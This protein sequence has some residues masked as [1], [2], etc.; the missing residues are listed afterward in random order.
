MK[1]K[2]SNTMCKPTIYIFLL[3]YVI[4]GG[5]C[6]A[7]KLLQ[8]TENRSLP[9]AYGQKEDSATIATVPWK[10]F[11]TDPLLQA[12]IDTAL[13]RNQEL[14]STWQEIQIARNEIRMRRAPL[15]PSVGARLGMGI[16]K[17]GRYTSQG[18]GDASTEMEPGKEVPDPLADITAG[19]YANWELDIWKK[20]RNAKKASINRYL[21][22]IEGKNFVLTSL[23]AEVATAYFEL[24]ALDNEL[25]IVQQNIQLQQNAW[26]VVKVQKEAARTTELAVQKFGAELLGSQSLEFDIRQRISETEN[27]LNFLL[28]RFAQPIPR[29]KNGFLERNPPAVQAGVPSQLLANR[30]DIKQAELELAAA[31]LDVKTARSEFYPS[32]GIS[33]V[34]GVQAFK[35]RYLIRFP[36]SVLYSVAGDLAAPVINRNA[37][38]AEFYKANARQVQAMYH[39]EQRIVNACLEV[40]T[41]LSRIEN[42]EK[43]YELKAK[44][45]AALSHSS[46]IA[47]DLFRAARADYFEVLM[48]Q[49]DALEAKLELVETKKE[50][51]AAV[52]AIYRDL[53]GGWH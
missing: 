28:G 38:K 16:E 19:L 33:A 10:Q 53:G 50:Q 8:V 45:V 7:P 30:P 43:S 39:Y 47:N 25:E 51:L 2:K 21:S 41:Q 37:I 49:R 34:L 22:T 9:K 42:L 3:L 48:T 1:K 14:N 46:S 5:G 23:V 13:A 52:V 40:A 24:L 20:L 29:D 36:E 15:L 27:R 18:A 44:Q 26:E 6:Q 31:K 12:L 35:P 11:F 32:V 17:V 4:S